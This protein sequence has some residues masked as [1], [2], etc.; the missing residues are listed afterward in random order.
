MSDYVRLA[1]VGM[2]MTI[3]EG[4]LINKVKEKSTRPDIRD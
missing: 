3:S 4:G 2:I 1:P